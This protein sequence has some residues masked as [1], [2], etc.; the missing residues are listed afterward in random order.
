MSAVKHTDPVMGVDIHIVM[1]PTPGGPVPVPIPHPFVGMVMDPL[2]WIPITIMIPKV[3]VDAMM[4]VAEFKE[5][6]VEATGFDM[7]GQGMFPNE[8]E[9]GGDQPSAPPPSSESEA[10]TPSEEPHDG[11][12][13]GNLTLGPSGPGWVPM[14]LNA[15]VWV[16]GIPRGHAT[17]NGFGAPHTPIGGPTFQRPPVMT[18]KSTCELLLGSKT[19]IAE[20]SPFTFAGLPTLSCSCVGSPAPADPKGEVEAGLFLPT[21]VVLAIPAGRPVLVGGPPVPNYMAMLGKAFGGLRRLQRRSKSMKR[22]SKKLNEKAAKKFKSKLAR[23]LASKVICMLTGHP[24][25]VATGKVLTDLVDFELPGPIPLVWERTWYSTSEN[26][27]ALG[28]GWHHSYDMALAIDEAEQVVGLRMADGR[29]IGSPVLQVGEDHLNAQE[30]LRLYRDDEGYGIFNLNDQVTYR[31]ADKADQLGIRQLTKIESRTGHT[32]HFQYSGKGHLKNII[33][34]S[35]RLIKVTTDHRGRITQIEA[36]HPKHP[37]QYFAIVSYDYDRVGDLVQSKDALGH[38][39]QYRYENHLLVQETSPNGLSFYFEYEGKDHNAWCLRTWGDGGIYDHKLTY[40]KEDQYTIV[41]NSLGHQSTHYWNDQGVVYR[42]LDP[43]GHT[44]SKR[45][46][47]HCNIV[48]ETDEIGRITTHT[49]DEESNR[50][51]TT[52]PDESTLQMEYANGLLV[53]ATDQNGG[54]WS[55]DYDGKGQLVTRI[56]P[57]GHETKYSYQQGLLTRIVDPA[58]GITTLQYDDRSNLVKLTTP[59]RAESS[60]TYDLLGRCTSATDPKGNMQRRK[61]N[62]NGWVKQVNEPD[63]NIRQLDYDAEGNVTRAK[64]KQHDVHFEYAGMSRLKARAEAG[65][66]VEFKY[67]TEE[68]LIGI[69]NE[70]GYAYRFELDANSEVIVESGFDGVT[71]RYSRDAAGRVVEVSR[72]SGLTTQYAYDGVDRVIKV[73]HSDG[74]EEQFDYRPDGELLSAKNRHILIQFERDELGQVLKEQ[75]GPFVIES[76]Y[77]DLGMRTQLTSS[78]GANVS[79]D[80]NIMGDV[81]KVTAGDEENPWEAS[82]KRDNLGLELERVLPGGVR[83]TWQ[84]DRLGRPV[85]QKT[86]LTGGKITRQ[87][88]YTWGVNDRLKQIT[89]PQQGTWRFQHDDLGN[90]ASARYPDGTTELRMPDAVGSLFKTNDRSDRKYGPAGQLLEADGTRY[91]YDKEGNLIKKIE[92]DGKVWT[93]SWNASGMLREV[94]RP[95]RN[96]VTFTYDALGRR[97]SKTY[98]GKI[99]RWVWDGNVPLH[100][101]VEDSKQS[102]VGNR[103]SDEETQGARR[104]KIRRRDEKL[105][106]SP[107]NAPP[108]QEK[109]TVEQIQTADWRLETEKLPADIT[110]WLFEPESFAPMAKLRDDKQYAVVTDHLGTPTTMYSEAG[111]KVWEMDLSIYGE[112]KKVEG[113]E[114]DCPFRYPGQYEDV[115]T[116]LYYNR[117]RYYDPE[118]GFYVSQDPIGIEG[119]LHFHSYVPDTNSWLDPFGLRCKPIRAIRQLFSRIRTALG[120]LKQWIRIGPSYSHHLGQRVRLSIRWGASPARGGR[121]IRQIGSP[122]MQRLNQWLRRRRVRIPGWRGKDPGHFHILK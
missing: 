44:S 102:A 42:S 33:D 43:L 97:I 70:H 87:R 16:N 27:T 38:A 47:A 10:E 48:S 22:L 122:T 45:Y 89:D 79:F 61:F 111:D 90:L 6:A 36:P 32:I 39:Y 41:E 5:S 100:E 35:G 118:G 106:S 3:A 62:L 11:N 96:K 20:T 4:K 46:D 1:V 31:F 51:G 17:T 55:W 53:A 113:F 114:G 65:T 67:N 57:L 7:G 104:I 14:P 110:T 108:P 75:Q 86:T 34:S 117:F 2:D 80:R 19:V 107:S 101:W 30:R 58:G 92:P 120:P 50:T 81:E 78:L 13:E 98:R 77:N 52:F 94:T 99:T 26:E 71:R 25:D 18:Q 121:Y 15:S 54:S 12:P 105:T 72:A 29:V 88:Q 115:E 49:Y 69:I 37:D 76:V 8:G 56:N 93:Y 74:S 103:Q 68:D 64:D 9:G 95:D 24:V 116:G 112:V 21:S 85:E 83:S 23:N 91:E 63:T 73:T 60:W 28:H 59:D 40:F 119:G 109:Q 82:F 84:R 66:R